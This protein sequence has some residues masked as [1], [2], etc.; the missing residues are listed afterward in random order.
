MSTGFV[1][2]DDVESDS[3]EDFCSIPSQLLAA[4]DDLLAFSLPAQSCTQ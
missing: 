3:V 2:L 1:L 4:S